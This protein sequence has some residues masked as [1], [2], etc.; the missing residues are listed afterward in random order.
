[1]FKVD[2]ELI[3]DVLKE[4]RGDAGENVEMISGLDYHGAKRE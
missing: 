2:I 1:V 3:L 4:L